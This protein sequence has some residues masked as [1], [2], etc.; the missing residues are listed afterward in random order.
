[1]FKNKLLINYKWYD[2]N[3]LQLKNLNDHL[4]SSHFEFEIN[5]N[6]ILVNMLSTLTKFNVIVI[7][8]NN[9]QHKLTNAYSII[10]NINLHRT[11]VTIIKITFLSMTRINTH[12]N[13]ENESELKEYMIS[14][15][16]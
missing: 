3:N 8:N 2:V 12:L 11:K 7:D 4:W 14:Q 15:L 10:D 13:L 16:D 5:S 9:H 1:M 6:H